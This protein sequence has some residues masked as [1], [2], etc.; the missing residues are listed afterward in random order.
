[1]DYSEL[2]DINSDVF[3]YGLCNTLSEYIVHCK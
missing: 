3:M 1:M 2:S